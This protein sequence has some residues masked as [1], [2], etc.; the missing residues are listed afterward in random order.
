MMPEMAKRFAGNIK[1]EEE[2]EIMVLEA[3]RQLH[4]SPELDSGGIL[5]FPNVDFDPKSE[6]LLYMYIVVVFKTII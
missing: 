4:K 3:I 6:S 2:G 5:V 1:G